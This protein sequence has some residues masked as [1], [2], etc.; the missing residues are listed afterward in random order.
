MPAKATQGLDSAAARRLFAL[1]AQHS[2]GPAEHD[3]S[4]EARKLFATLGEGDSASYH[5]MDAL[6]R[7]PTTGGIIFVGNESAARGPLSYFKA[8]DITHVVNATD[9]LPNFCDGGVKYMRF[10]AAHHMRYSGDSRSL[11]D[12]VTPLFR[13]VDEALSAGN[14]VLV[15]CLAG[16][17]R[18]GTTGCLLLMWKEALSAEDATALAQQR[19]PVINP[20]G[21]L[22]QLLARFEALRRT[23]SAWDGWEREARAAFEARVAASV[24]AEAEDARLEQVKA[25]DD[26]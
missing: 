3:Y 17:H 7:D 1:R 10:H 26:L 16:A 15:H 4:A 24:L 23:S 9:D 19:R 12:F 6:W 13:F 22:P 2:P 5:D 14:N 20:I 18:A 21:T 11:L 8:A 25:A